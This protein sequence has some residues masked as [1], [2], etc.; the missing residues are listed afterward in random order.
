MPPASTDP[1][2]SPHFSLPKH[3]PFQR[4]WCTRILS[5]LSF[6]MLAVAMGWHIYALTHSA[7]ALGLVGL[8]QFLPMFLLTLVVGHVADR[9]DRRRIAAVCQSLESVAALLFAIGTFSGWISAPV[10]Y[11]LAACVGASRAFESPAVSSLLPAVVPRGYLPKA[12]AWSTSAN[13]TAQIAGPALGGL[14][15]G[16]G[17]G[18]AYL[19]CTLSF[20]AAAASV[21]SIP[22]QV[23]PASR[24]PVTLESIFSGIAFIRREPVILGALSLDLFAVLFGGAT[25]LLPIFARDV[26]HTGPIGLGLLRSGTAIGAL[27]GTIWLA[28]FPL[29]NRPGAAMFGGV[30]AFGI[31][32]IV[33]G[34]SHQFL[35]SLLALMVLGASDTISVVVRLSLVQL[36]TPDEMLGRVSA[37]NS[38]FIGTSNQLG[39]FESGLTA[40]WWGAQPAV[41][42]GG[43][44]TIAIALLWMRF[45]PEL[46]HTRTLEREEALAASA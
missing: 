33:F 11:V 7:F 16:I 36:R 27:A 32:T 5:S 15:Y 17:P 29:R 12:T 46:R 42:V 26:L 34:L 9:Y 21:W 43:V 41:L 45:F 25:A 6:Q 30:I 18:A 44:A 31:A 4:F 8:A 23:K 13:Q 37:V 20:A 39:E 38:L 2:D 3:P 19:A 28:H 22:L 14:L 35:V 1:A 40:G 10:I 24:A